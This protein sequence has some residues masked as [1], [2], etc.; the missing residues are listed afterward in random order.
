MSA[1]EL[2]DRLPKVNSDPRLGDLKHI[3]TLVDGTLLRALPRI[4]EAMWLST[5]TGTATALARMF[6][7]CRNQ[8]VRSSL[9]MSRLQYC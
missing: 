8:G 2:T 7:P 9:S 4:T 1:V 3:I 5:R 6:C